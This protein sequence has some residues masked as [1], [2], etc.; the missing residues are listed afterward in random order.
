MADY[1]SARTVNP[2]PRWFTSYKNVLDWGS[3]HVEKSALNKLRAPQMDPSQC[4]LCGQKY[5][6][7]CILALLPTKETCERLCDLFFSTVF[8]LLPLLHPPGFAKDFQMFWEER[9]GSTGHDSGVGSLVRRKPSFVSLLFSM[10]FAALKCA[11]KSRLQRIL[12]D[13][14]DFIAGDIYLTAV[15]AITLTG[16]P[17]RPS[18]YSLAA[19]LLTQSPFVM[20]E[21]FSDFPDFI[22]TAFR[23][24]LSMGLHRQLPEAGFDNSELET[25][26]RLWWYIL[27]LD[28]MSSASSG[29]SPLFIDSKMANVE[30]ISQCDHCGD[31]CTGEGHLRKV[32]NVPLII[33]W[34]Y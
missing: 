13:S 5:K 16:F 21:D 31:S 32:Q 29:L 19:Y 10:I 3:E 12:G 18:H 8:P 7:G 23:V 22:S 11:S 26:R 14:S 20:E 17:R 15:V 24:G 30:M 27:H 1:P 9:D 33:K 34:H 28:V 4:R 25:R 6:I 2:F